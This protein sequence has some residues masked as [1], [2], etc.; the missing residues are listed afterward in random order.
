M[1]S[2]IAMAEHFQDVPVLIISC[3]EGRPEGRNPERLAGLHGTILPMTWSLMLALRAR[4]VGAAWTT[5]VFTYEKEVVELLN[6]P[7]G[8]TPAACLPVAYLTGEDFKP[9]RRVPA[10]D[11]T[12]WNNWGTR[13]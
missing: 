6:I 3:I 7:Q 8:L 4:G 9:A 13:R 11:R 10:R 12:Y 2:A 5:I 1:E